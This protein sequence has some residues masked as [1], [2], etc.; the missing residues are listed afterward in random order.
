MTTPLAITS[1][2]TLEI[3]GGHFIKEGSI[4]MSQMLASSFLLNSNLPSVSVARLPTLFSIQLSMGF[5]GDFS[6]N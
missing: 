3:D 5:A 1:G 6:D 4:N 2:W